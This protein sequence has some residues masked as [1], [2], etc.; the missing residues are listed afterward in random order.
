[1]KQLLTLIKKDL[2]LDYSFLINYKEMG[3]KRMLTN[4]IGYLVL[5]LFA[6]IPIRFIMG[7]YDNPLILPLK[8]ILLAQTVVSAY[9]AV[10][11]FYLAPIVS[12]IYFSNDINILLGLPVKATNIL[13]SK[14]IS[15]TLNSMIVSGLVLLPSGVKYGMVSSKGLEYYIILVLG[16][17]LSNAMTIAILTLIIVAAMRFIN[18][19]PN[20]KNIMQTIGMIF[21]IIFSIGLQVAVRTVDFTGENM[22][23]I[24]NSSRELLD[25]LLLAMPHLRPLVYSL[26]AESSGQSII[27][28]LVLIALAIIILFLVTRLGYNLML[29]GIFDNKTILSKK[30]TKT[31]KVHS[32]SPRM[33]IAKKDVKEILGTPVYIYNVLSTGI[34]MPVL[35]ILPL[36]TNENI[37]LSELMNGEKLF[38]MMGI[39]NFDQLVIWMLAGLMISMVLSM[40]GP[41]SSSALSREGKSMWLMKILPIKYEDILVGKV[42]ASM[43]FQVLGILPTT[44]LLFFILKPGIISIVAYLLGALSSIYLVSNFGMTLGIEHV[45]LDWDNPQQI[46]KNTFSSLVMAFGSL[47]YMFIVGFGMFNLINRGVLNFTTAKYILVV[48]IAINYL[49]GYL[50]SKSNVGR[51]KRRLITYGE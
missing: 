38:E 14:I 12:T 9:I 30:R 21:I 36:I 27:W 40:T 3:S 16:W 49:I 47:G 37:S 18:R 33:A 34:L 24:L 15:L 22:A 23:E 4:F 10:I 31:E 46:I 6:I 35:F 7:M 28:F 19:I 20:I 43:F 2:L 17:V 39:S 50:L 41:T 48:L 29:K 45:K 42:L 8:D 32:D 1:M 13:L 25:S 5:G 44:I 11:F 51:L 26:T